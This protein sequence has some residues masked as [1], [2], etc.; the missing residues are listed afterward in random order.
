VTSGNLF[1]DVPQQ[2]EREQFTTLLSSPMLRIERIV[3]CGQASP[4]DFWYDQE[5]AEWVMVL[6][7]SARLQFEDEGHAR[8]LGPGDHLHIAA[9]RRHRVTWTDPSQPTIWL[10]V[11]YR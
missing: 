10:A 11:H 9:H 3:S 5:E 7:G 6:A 4:P 8:H 2:L 1:A